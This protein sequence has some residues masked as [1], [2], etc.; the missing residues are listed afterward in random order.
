MMP[1]QLI[2]NNSEKQPIFYT[3]SKREP[4]KVSKKKMN[5]IKQI[6]SLEMLPWKGERDGLERMVNSGLET[7]KKM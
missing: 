3:E 6:N 5:I 1:E 4:K 7:N 2:Q